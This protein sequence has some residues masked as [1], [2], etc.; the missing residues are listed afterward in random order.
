MR[1]RQPCQRADVLRAIEPTQESGQ[2]QCV[3][4]RFGNRRDAGT[5]AEL[6]VTDFHAAAG[7]AATSG[8]PPLERE[9]DAGQ[10]LP[11]KNES[12]ARPLP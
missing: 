4:F 6:Q 9:L 7:V 3:R 2:H 11:V 1:R 5:A 10:P 12:R 8:A